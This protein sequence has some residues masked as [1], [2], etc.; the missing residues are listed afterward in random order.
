MSSP[1]T[2]APEYPLV[3]A[4]FYLT[5]GC[6]LR[7]RHCWIVPEGKGGGQGKVFLDPDLVREIIRQARPLG[8]RVAKL[9]GGEPLLHPGIFRI[10]EIIR[11]EHVA[12]AVE[13]NGVL[14]TPELAAAMAACLDPFVS[15]RLD[16]A[17][18]ET[19]DWL[20]GVPD[21]FSRT[22]QGIKALTAA[23]V[24][25]QLIFTL[26]QRNRGQVEQVARLARD[27]GAVSLKIN[28]LQPTNRGLELHEQGEALPIAELVAMGRWA[29][30]ELAPQV[31]L[32]ILFDQPLAFRSLHRMFGETGLGCLTCGILGTLGV[33]ADGS[34]ALCGIGQ[35]LPELVF[36]QAAREPLAEVWWGHPVLTGLRQGLP[37]RL[38]GICRDC[39]MKGR[40]LGSCLAQNYYRT[41][42]LWAPYWFC[43]AAAE[44]G[45]FP[46]SRRRPETGAFNFT[47]IP[48]EA[49]GVQPLP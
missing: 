30:T 2:P 34:Y 41:G 13:T 10:L 39:L 29:E 27:L 33:L 38:Q 12:L 26:M 46:A 17:D 40:C 16:G 24:R 37:G 1:E 15:V 32:P 9:T 4:Y 25:P 45:L 6:N 20:R 18:A 22:L 3:Q 43:E 21:C 49:T 8:L 47:S 19:H 5:E 36:G 44:A 11:E 14:C 31:G 35:F 48:P 7:C 42:N 28:V 23:G